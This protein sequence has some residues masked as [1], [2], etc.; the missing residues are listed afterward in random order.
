MASSDKYCSGRKILVGKSLFSIRTTQAF[1][2]RLRKNL[3]G[4]FSS[5]LN[6][7]DLSMP[8]R[9][10]H[11]LTIFFLVISMPLAL[12][13]ETSSDAWVTMFNGQD[14]S[15]WRANPENPDSFHVEN[16]TLVVDGPRCHLFWVGDPE[17]AENEQ[18]TDFHWHAKVKTMPKANGGLYFHT[19]YEDS[20]WPSAG[21]ECQVNQTHKDRKKTGGLYAVA[22]VL[23]TSPVKDGEWYDYD[24]IVEGKHIVLKINGE[25]TTDW[26]E[27]DDWQP[28]KNMAGRKLSQGTFAIQAH[29]PESVVFYKDIRFKRIP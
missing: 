18:L 28:P 8:L 5:E 1:M 24:I 29:D 27:P 15:G 10:R 7:G 9:N 19:Q 6:L 20:G 13:A 11:L 3:I 2:I 22:D 17:N 16:G 4:T 21:Y 25:I 14:L 26:T 12:P 23:D